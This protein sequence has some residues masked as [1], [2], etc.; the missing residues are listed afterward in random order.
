M[1][2]CKVCQS[3]KPRFGA[4][5]NCEAEAQA[6]EKARQAA[7]QERLKREE[8]ERR[9]RQI[10]E[11]VKHHYDDF[12]G[13]HL[14]EATAGINFT[15]AA[16]GT[17][18]GMVSTLLQFEFT[19][20]LSVDLALVGFQRIGTDWR[21][22]QYFND[23]LFFILDGQ[24]HHIPDPYTYFQVI[25]GG[26]VEIVG[27]HP[28][29]AQLDLMISDQEWRVRAGHWEAKPKWPTHQVFQAAVDQKAAIIAGN[30]PSTS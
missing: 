3:E 13:R 8:E 17:L 11:S 24:S 21:W 4:C 7:K 28:S 27:F 9:E 25:D 18:D 6:K 15:S 19:R 10:R 14:V 23:Q 26:V 12:S 22:M 20:D 29:K 5:A 2:T 1:A 30:N 16:S